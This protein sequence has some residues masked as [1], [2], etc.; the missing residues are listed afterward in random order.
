MLN[1]IKNFFKKEEKKIEQ[2]KIEPI[3]CKFPKIKRLP[4]SGGTS[5]VITDVS[6][7]LERDIVIIEK[8]KGIDVRMTNSNL[9]TRES[10]LTSNK[11]LN[12]LW[13][14]IKN[15]IPAYWQ[16]LG[17]YTGKEYNGLPGTFVLHS[18]RLNPENDWVSWSDV[19]TVGKSFAL[20]ITMKFWGGSLDSEKELQEITLRLMRSNS[21]TDLVLRDRHHFL[22]INNSVAKMEA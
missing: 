22:N 19:K 4:W 12:I 9:V 20:P 1:K 7:F 13:N 3:A 8:L 17:T 15:D 5:P 18:I 6:D 10:A 2:P 16:L 14:T 21:Y 11:E